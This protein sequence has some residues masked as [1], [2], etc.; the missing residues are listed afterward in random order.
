MNKI[1]KRPWG[2]YVVLAKSKDFLIKKIKI[3]H[4]HRKKSEPK[5]NKKETN[6]IDK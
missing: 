4:N 6:Y 2:N 1:V 3:K 5:I